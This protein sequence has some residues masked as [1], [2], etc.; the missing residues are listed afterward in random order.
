MRKISF[1]QVITV[2]FTSFTIFGCSNDSSD[3]NKELDTTAP[4]ISCFENIEVKIDATAS[5]TEVSFNTPLGTDDVSEVSTKQTKGL[6]S[7]SLFPVGSTTNT[8]STTDAAGNT[9]SCSFNV[10]VT[11]KA[12]LSSA[13]YFV[14]NNPTPK[15]KKWEKVANK[16]DEFDGTAFDD[17]KWHKN[18]A[19][20]GFGWYGRPPALFDPENV[21]VNDG[22]LN[23]TTLKYDTPKTANSRDW[24]HGGA[25]VR[26]KETVKAGQYFECRMKANKTV[27]SSTFWLSFKQN[28]NTGPVRKLE[29]DV[30]ECVGRTHAGTA[31]W[32][33]DF[34]NIYHSNTWRHDRPCDTAIDESKQAPAIKI[35]E[36]ENNSRYFVY[37]CW[38][39]SPKEIL[40]YLDGEFSHAI[41]N[42]PADF[43]LE[44]HI[45][46]AIETYNWNPIDADNIFE[47]ASYDDLTTKYDW[48]RTWDLV[49]E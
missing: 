1:I 48:V 45:T 41:T 29:L 42:P 49:D 18:P 36:E 3:E 30:Q 28:C 26:S 22:N 14:G 7:G 8:F 10:I 25:I 38:W 32:A 33:K 4:E 21:T 16:S 15:G 19:T 34:A 47:T 24:T 35:L 31:V 13:P 43:D 27:M 11:R 2:V 9:A 39:K 40:F 5:G 46:M 37:G 23:I 6:T 20:D 44:G 17:S 12:P